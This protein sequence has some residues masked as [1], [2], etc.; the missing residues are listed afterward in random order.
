MR[1]VLCKAL[2][3]LVSLVASFQTFAAVLEGGVVAAPDAYG[4]EVAAQVLK[5]GGN[6]VDAVV[7]QKNT[8]KQK[9][10]LAAPFFK[11]A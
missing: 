6:A 2:V 10:G 8:R 4:A 1:F 7:A 5:R 3:L 9:R 11:L